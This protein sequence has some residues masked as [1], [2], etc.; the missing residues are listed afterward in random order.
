MQGGVAVPRGRIPRARPRGPTNGYPCT[1]ESW[2]S[3]RDTQ[4]PGGG[5]VAVSFFLLGGGVYPELGL[6]LKVKHAG[7]WIALEATM[8]WG[9]I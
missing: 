6:A 7:G 8:R 2:M 5:A 1:P 4:Q 3:S 9:C